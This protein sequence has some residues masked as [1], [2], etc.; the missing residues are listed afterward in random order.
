MAIKRREQKKP[1]PLAKKPGGQ[2]TQNTLDAKRARE[3]VAEIKSVL[4][5]GQ[6][7]NVYKIM[8]KHG[9]SESSAKAN[10]IKKNV[11]YQQEM[12]TF[13]NDI[14]ELRDDALY[15]ARQTI[16][17]GKYK[18]FIDTI[19]KLSKIIN[20]ETGKPTELIGAKLSMKERENLDKLI[21]S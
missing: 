7:P 9:Y 18:D 5:A 20:L 10:S 21:E 17:T 12:D 13:L 8:K 16:V 1:K 3:T 11:Y 19:D 14:V 2:A 6:R 15:A 4:M